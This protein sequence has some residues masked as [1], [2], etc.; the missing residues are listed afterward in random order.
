MPAC[1]GR[2]EEEGPA[3]AAFLDCTKAREG[4]PR[5]SSDS[6]HMGHWVHSHR[7]AYRGTKSRARQSWGGE[8]KGLETRQGQQLKNR[9]L[10]SVVPT[11]II[12]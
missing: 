7:L 8:P 10:P 12:A 3:W 11:Y 4:R 1:S 6:C 5:A 9:F 2:V